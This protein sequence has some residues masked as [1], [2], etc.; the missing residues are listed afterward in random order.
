MTNALVEIGLISVSVV[1]GLMGFPIW[2]VAVM[3]GVSSL[4]WAIVHHK[5]FSAMLEAG[6]LG[7]IGSL[8][9]AFVVL[10]FGHFV[11]YGLGGAFHKILGLT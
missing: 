10:G 9:V 11:G 3:I 5:R 7:A 1:L 4:W 2:I 6:A 8:A